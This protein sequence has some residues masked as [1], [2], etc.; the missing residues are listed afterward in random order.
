MH[1]F[2]QDLRDRDCMTVFMVTHD[3]EEAFKLGDRVLVF[4]KPKWDPDD[5]QKYGATITYDFDARDG[6]IPFQTLMETPMYWRPTDRTRS[7]HPAD[8][9]RTEAS[10]IT[11]PT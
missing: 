5:P 1:E 2:L 4:D 10:R 3:L 6:G 9:A 7:H 11:T 8:R